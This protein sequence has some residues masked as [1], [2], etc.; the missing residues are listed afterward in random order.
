M[1]QGAHAG[2]HACTRSH[3]HMLALQVHLMV[4]PYPSRFSM[5]Q[6]ADGKGKQDGAQGRTSIHSES[7]VLAL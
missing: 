3:A 2:A 5:C 4:S 6:A 1:E 7:H